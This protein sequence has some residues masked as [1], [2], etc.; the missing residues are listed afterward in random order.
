MNK[1]DLIKE[2]SFLKNAKRIYRDNA[3]N[4]IC[5]H[6]ETFPHLLKLVFDTQSKHAI[7]ATWV[8]EIDF[9]K[10]RILRKCWISGT[11]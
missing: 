1:S 10:K 2:L 3:A 9:L 7:K 8:L 6:P 4:F 11:Y 5:Q